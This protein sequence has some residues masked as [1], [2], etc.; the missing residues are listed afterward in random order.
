MK[1]LTLEMPQAICA[2]RCA[3]YMKDQATLLFITFFF[4]VQYSCKNNENGQSEHEFQLGNIIDVEYSA[5]ERGNYNGKEENYIYKTSKNDTLTFHVWDVLNLPNGKKEPLVFDLNESIGHEFLVK[6]NLLY[7]PW[8]GLVETAKYS[9]II[10]NYEYILHRFEIEKPFINGAGFNLYTK[11]F[12]LVAS[13]SLSW[14]NK[15]II[16]GSS[17]EPSR[18]NLDKLRDYLIADSL[19]IFTPKIK[20]E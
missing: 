14:D 1:D 17:Y 5:F 12:G 19:E 8:D 10:N 13:Y 15:S 7:Y 16:S 4:F 18:K 11:E 20:K 2:K 3:S 6:D 9:V